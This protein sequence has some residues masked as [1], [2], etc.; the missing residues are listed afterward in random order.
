ME[1]M[2][3]FI[4]RNAESIDELVPCC[5][6]P[7]Q[8]PFILNNLPFGKDPPP[9]ITRFVAVDK[10]VRL[11]VLDWGGSGRPLVL[12]AGGGDTAHLLD[13]C[14]L[15]LTASFHVYGITRHGFGKSGYSASE[16]GADRL[17][18]DVLLK[19]PVLVGHSIDGEELS[20]VASRYLSRVAGLVYLEA[21]YPYAFDKRQRTDDEGVSGNQRASTPTPR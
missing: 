4:R 17:G 5:L 3:R 18:D 7:S 13:E 12:L 1:A 20:S 10:N 14:A 11:E 16:Y 9:H 6:S 8:F 15:K 19:R 2:D 21:G